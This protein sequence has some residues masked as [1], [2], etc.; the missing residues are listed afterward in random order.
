MIIINIYVLIPIF[1]ISL[2]SKSFYLPFKI[3]DTNNNYNLIENLFNYNLVVNINIG[4]GNN[5]IKLPMSLSLEDNPT[6]ILD[7]SA[8]NYSLYNSKLSKTYKTDNIKA[9]I[10]Y[11]DYNLI[12]SNETFNLNDNI[13]MKNYSFILATNYTKENYFKKYLFINNIT[14]GKIGLGLYVFN[15]DITYKTNF[16][17][18]LKEQ[19]IISDFNF[20]FKFSKDFKNGKFYIGK[21]PS[22]F[23]KKKYIHVKADKNGFGYQWMI[24]FQKIIN[25]NH[26]IADHINTYI[27]IETGF[28]KAPTDYQH[29]IINNFFNEFF[30]K[31]ICFKNNFESSDDWFYIYCNK[32]FNIKLFKPLIFLYKNNDLN[33]NIEFTYKDLFIKKG[34]YYFFLII[35]GKQ[36]L[37][38]DFG[39]PFFKKYKIIFDNE[40]QIMSIYNKNFQ[41]ENNFLNEIKK[42]KN[43]F[44][45]IIIIIILILIIIIISFY[46]IKFFKSMPRK[47]KSNELLDDN[48]EYISQNEYEKNNKLLELNHKN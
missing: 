12:I 7:Y 46:F 15:Y 9:K 34:N 5:K 19:K 37:T 26:T 47:K 21:L 43:F 35:F 23:D 29:F 18:Q 41:S 27:S 16:I 11:E 32:N 42:N 4:E 31:S 17:H 40:N 20:Y 44:I 1:I 8:Y 36:K 25:D 6:S 10:S 14:F 30:N 45:S 28:L 38:W 48:Y 22:S 33:F 24:I 3:G 2:K 13:I 39:E